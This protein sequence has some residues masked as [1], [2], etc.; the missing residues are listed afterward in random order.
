MRILISTAIL[1]V[2]VAGQAH[3]ADQ[4]NAV[5]VGAYVYAFNSS[6]TDLTGPFTPPG[7]RASEENVD[8][9]ALIYTRMLMPDWSVTLALGA[10]P[11]YYLVGQGVA[12]SL[13]RISEAK[14]ISPAL[15]GQHHWHFENDRLEPFL[16]VG[17]NY[18]HFYHL[19]AYQSLVTALG[20]PTDLSVGDRYAPLATAGVNV[21]IT[22]QAFLTFAATYIYLSANAHL[23]TSAVSRSMEMDLNPVVYRFTAGYRF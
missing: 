4:S 19:Q 5:S 9:L 2:C 8:T 6:S 13:G 17:I 15:I 20:G 12:R 16:G 18:N 1:L 7:I 10:P 11:T 21:N 23:T 3:G 14:V 22:S